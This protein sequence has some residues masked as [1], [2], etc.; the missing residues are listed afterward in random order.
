[1]RGIHRKVGEDPSVWARP[2]PFHSYR[3]G[4]AEPMVPGEVT[5]L[6]FGLQPISVLFRK[7]HRIRVSIAGH[8]VSVFRRIPSEG[9]PELRIQ[10]NS[11]HPSRIELPVIRN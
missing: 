2:I 1:L 5:E 10:R 7:G 9:T 4:D 11:V 3:S 8:D 6:S